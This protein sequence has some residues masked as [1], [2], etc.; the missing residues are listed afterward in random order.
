MKKV[1]RFVDYQLNYE[2][3]VWTAYEYIESNPN[4]SGSSLRIIMIINCV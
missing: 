1:A 2:C 4:M 3:L